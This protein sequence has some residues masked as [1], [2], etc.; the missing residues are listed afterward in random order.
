MWQ[1]EF[2][3][4]EQFKLVPIKS[5]DFDK[6]FMA[7]SDPL[8]WEQHPASDRYKI[9]VFQQYFEDALNSKMAF[10]IV[11]KTD[12]SVIGSTRYYNYDVQSN[13]VAIGYTFIARKYWG[14]I[15]NR[16][17]KK[18][19]LDYAFRSVNQVFFHIGVNNIR[20]Q[21]AVEKIGATR[22]RELDF[23]SNGKL[24]PYVEYVIQKHTYKPQ[25][26]KKQYVGEEELSVM[27]ANEFD[28]DFILKLQKL[29][30]LEEGA[31]YN[32]FSI[33]PLTQSKDS[34][35]TEWEHGT[36]LKAIVNDTIVGSV[37]CEL[38]NDICYIGKLIVSPEFQN[39]GIGGKLLDSIEQLYSDC[40]FYELFTGFKSSKNILFY[41]RKGYVIFKEKPIN[42]NL[43]LVFLRKINPKK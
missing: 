6:L 37:R 35:L 9:S 32:D 8:I 38:K 18:L 27:P 30:Y 25:L 14:G 20:S 16:S 28:L 4:N 40:S 26:F 23:E 29:V 17:I 39:R 2:L 10:I 36:F 3:E 5:T 11:D 42:E 33:Q 1:P 34:I 24:L 12:D 22:V 43:T 15:A 7:A 13:S 41:Q 21:K 19:L 31:L